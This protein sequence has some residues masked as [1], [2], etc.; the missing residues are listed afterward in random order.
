MTTALDS[1]ED[2]ILLARMAAGDRA[3]FGAFVARHQ[4]AVLRFARLSTSRPSE[5]EDVL[6]ETFLAAL[7]GAEGYRGDGS[8]R[9]WLLTIARRTAVRL[10]PRETLL[11]DGA[12]LET[13]GRRAGWGEPVDPERSAIAVEQAARVD[14]AL[15]GLSA[16]DREIL[17]LRDVEGLSGP[18]TCEVLGL[19][20]PAMK[21]RLHR[22]RLRFVEKLH[23]QE[24]GHE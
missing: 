6:Q 9:G 13:L 24:V 1:P 16:E 21:S 14:L 4:A 23:R 8:A 19:G 3:A 11:D 22:A 10:R 12:D 18:A 7:R 15:S 17:L 2:A 5:A 20:E